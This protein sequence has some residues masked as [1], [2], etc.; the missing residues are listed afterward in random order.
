[1]ENPE[2]VDRMPSGDLLRIRE[3]KTIKTNIHYKL[4]MDYI[5]YMLRIIQT[6]V[7]C[8]NIYPGAKFNVQELI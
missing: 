5:L 4:K 7:D 1:M 6:Y 3:N 8:E 2:K